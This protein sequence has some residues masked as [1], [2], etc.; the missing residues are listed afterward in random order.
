MK[1]QSFYIKYKKWIT[2][3]ALY[4]LM[5]FILVIIGVFSLI[6]WVSYQ[7]LTEDPYKPYI[8]GGF[9]SGWSDGYYHQTGELTSTPWHIYNSETYKLKKQV[10]IE[11]EEYLAN[12]LKSE[13]GIK[14]A[15]M[16][17]NNIKLP[18]QLELEKRFTKGVDFYADYVKQRVKRESY[19]SDKEYEDALE[20]MA[21]K[22]GYGEGYIE[23]LTGKSYSR[24]IRVFE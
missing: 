14:L 6:G 11:R 1:E 22:V 24:A 13:H 16:K 4:Q 2:A 9:K 19:K 5:W 10:T 21:W 8:R 12:F 18:L 17:L 15:E 23:G 20:D 3:I 7:Y